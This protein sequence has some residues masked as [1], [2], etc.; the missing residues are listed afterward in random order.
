MLKIP[1]NK[2][3]TNNKQTKNRNVEVTYGCILREFN[4]HTTKYS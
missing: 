4:E 1:K 2:K 3:Q